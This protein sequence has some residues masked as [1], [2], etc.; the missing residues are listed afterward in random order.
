MRKSVSRNQ[1]ICKITSKYKDNSNNQMQQ[2]MLHLFGGKRTLCSGV[3]HLPNDNSWAER[4]NDLSSIRVNNQPT[5]DI[6]RYSNNGLDGKLFG[7]AFSW[8]TKRKN[9]KI[10]C[11]CS[12]SRFENASE[13]VISSRG[14]SQYTYN[15]VTTYNA[16][17]THRARWWNGMF[18]CIVFSRHSHWDGGMALYWKF[19]TRLQIY[20]LDQR[21]R[22]QNISNEKAKKGMWTKWMPVFPIL[23][24]NRC[25]A[26]LQCC[27]M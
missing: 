22:A 8:I 1:R 20:V 10:K 23:M 14:L 9:R 4:V 18:S 17:I 12:S 6:T 3:T 15:H 21:L 2:K 16:R 25:F 27:R 13:K 26:F 19:L 7:H 5:W 24:P 11:K